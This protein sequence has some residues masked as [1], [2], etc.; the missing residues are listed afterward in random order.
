MI[1][2]W[3]AYNR[4]LAEKNKQVAHGHPDADNPDIIRNS[5]FRNN[6]FDETVTAAASG[7]IQS[8]PYVICG[9][10]TCKPVGAKGALR[11]TIKARMFFFG[12]VY[13]NYDNREIIQQQ[14]WDVMLEFISRYLEDHETTGMCGPFKRLDPEKM[15][16]QQVGPSS[17]NDYGWVL[18]LEFLQ[19]A[20]PLNFDASKWFS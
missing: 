20:D 4:T 2:A 11:L 12:R 14:T 10:V 16:W 7:N 1:I 8:N 18:D 3:Q 15:F 9:P 19:A 5:F 17:L 6:N 13:E